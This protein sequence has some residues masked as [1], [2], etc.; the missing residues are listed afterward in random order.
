M[1]D[2]SSTTLWLKGAAAAVIGAAANGVL[3]VVVNP[4]TFDIFSKAGWK[5]IATTCGATALVSLAGYL[6][7]SPLP[8]RTEQTQITVTKQTTD[9]KEP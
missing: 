1:I 9:T 3:V 8:G 4:G 6:K 7:Q 2:L 5:N